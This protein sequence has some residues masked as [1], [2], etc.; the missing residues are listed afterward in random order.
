MSPL[1]PTS[2]PTPARSDPPT[3]RSRLPYID[4]LRGLAVLMVLAYHCWVHT[5]QAPITV[6]ILGRRL[7][8]TAP[9]HLGYLGVHLFL[10]L[11]GF[12]LTYPLVRDNAIAVRLE[13]RRFFRRRGWRILPPYYAALLLLSL[14]PLVERGVRAAVG[15]S[16]AGVPT[17]TPGQ[18]LSHV[19]MVHNFSLAWMGAINASFWSLALE[20]QL[21]LV[22]PLLVWSFA[23]WGPA[24]SLAVVL[25]VTLSYRTWVYHTQDVSRLEVGYLYAYALPGRLFEFALG[26]MAALVLGPRSRG[27]A[28]QEKGSNRRLAGC[29]LGGALVLGLMGVVVAHRWSPFHPVTDVVWG[30]AFYCLVMYAGRRSQAGGGWLEARPLVGLG[31]ISYSVYLIHEPLVRRGYAAVAGLE[32]TPTLVLL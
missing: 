16:T 28:A 13:P 6:G 32:H 14:L 17:V 24:R 12:C 19:L 4:G 8:L 2:A 20:W 29:Y 30:L 18:V 22:F 11:S 15:A 5:I 10:V 26:M 9:L 27:E 1:A 21:Y 23:R 3:P 7:D 25:L 31:L